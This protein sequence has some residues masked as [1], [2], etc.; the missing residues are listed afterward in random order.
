M[1]ELDDEL[2]P[3]FEELEDDEESEDF[4]EYEED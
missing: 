4:D 3:E 1:T 2:E